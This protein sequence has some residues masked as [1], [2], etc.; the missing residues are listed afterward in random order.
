MIFLHT[1]LVHNEVV[2]KREQFLLLLKT[3]CLQ[4]Q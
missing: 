3:S 2:S 4:N 1:D